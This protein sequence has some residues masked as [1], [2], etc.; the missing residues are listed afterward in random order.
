MARLAPVTATVAP[1][2]FSTAALENAQVRDS[3]AFFLNVPYFAGYQ[4]SVQLIGNA[5]WALINIDTETQDFD[6]GHSTV[7]NTQRWNC[8]VAGVYE[9]SPV[10]AWAANGTGIRGVRV[11]KNNVAIPG[12]EGLVAAGSVT[13][14]TASAFTSVQC[15]VG[16]Y[17]EIWGYQSSGG[18]LNTQSNGE[19]ACALTCKWV[20]N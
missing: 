19:A 10:T 17:I 13:G 16:D 5:A 8:I 11:F 7:T 3:V 4:T 1:G 9:L 12:G 2:Q 20:K 14:T 6:G 15:A 18:N